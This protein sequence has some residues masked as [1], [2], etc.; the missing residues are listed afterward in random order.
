MKRILA[1]IVAVLM[2]ATVFVGCGTDTDKGA[3]ASNAD[4][5][6][7]HGEDNITLKVWAPNEAVE[8][9]QA[10]C[11]DFIAMYPDKT[12]S[13]EVVA[14][15][16]ADAATNLLNDPDAAADVFGFV[17]NNLNKLYNAGVITPV[18]DEFKE[19]VTKRNSEESVNAA[20][21]DDTL[22]AYPETGDNGYY[23]V[24]DKSV[25]TD[26]DAKTLEGVLKACRKAGRKFIMDAGNGYY[27]CI[28]TFTGGMELAG[29]DEDG[30][31]QF[32]DY[33]E[34]DVVASMQ[35]F[36]K[37][38]HE[39]KDIFESAEVSKVSSGMAEAKRTVAAGIDGSWNAKTVAS[40]LGDDYGA[41]KLP[42]I[43]VG[44]ADKQII[45]MHGYKLIGVNARTK[46]PETSQLLADYLSGEKCQ[47][48]RAEERSWGPSNIAATESDVVKNNIATTAILEQAKYSVAQ[49]GVADTFWDPMRTLGNKVYKPE[50]S[51]EAADLKDLLQKTVS[52]IKDE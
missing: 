45:S 50:E 10:Q 28:F 23:L 38:F 12:I 11:D 5:D 6:P 30:V 34:D 32:N 33:N 49:V 24:Y 25:V 17:C 20:T 52:N 51:T 27:S 22:L 15:G 47:L 42:T 37:L 40:V 39:Y 26:E 18:Y 41:A 48:E 4:T 3:T 21:L 29:L 36:S 35:A 16:E 9:F 7:F 8:T 44:G 31:Q 43:N 2:L 19:D 14:Q 1:L 46:F 13:I